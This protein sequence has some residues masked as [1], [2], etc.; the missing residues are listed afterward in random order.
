LQVSQASTRMWAAV[1][2]CRQ[3]AW[4]RLLRRRWA[5]DTAEFPFL[6]QKEQRRKRLPPSP[7]TRRTPESGRRHTTD[8]FLWLR[9]WEAW[10]ATRREIRRRVAGR[11]VRGTG[12]RRQLAGHTCRRVANRLRGWRS[13]SLKEV[14]T[15]AGRILPVRRACCSR[16]ER[17]PRK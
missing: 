4:F 7:S 14:E 16:V 13:R 10:E 5:E 12:R 11:L 8:R 2:R 6:E 17:K 3:G 15:F 1:R 9:Q